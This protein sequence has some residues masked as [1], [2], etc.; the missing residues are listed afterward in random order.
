MG[1][2]AGWGDRLRDNCAIVTVAEGT[3]CV[4]AIAGDA[5]LEDGGLRANRFVDTG[6]AGVDGISYA[7]MAEPVAFEKLRQMP[8]VPM[9]FVSFTLTL[10]A[11]GETVAQIPFRY[12]ED[13]SLVD[14]PAVPEKEGCYGAWPEFDTSGLNSDITLEAEYESLITLLASRE[15]DGNLALVLAEGAFTGD[16]VLRAENSG[17]TPPTAAG[18]DRQTDVWEITLTGTDLTESDTVPLRLLN[19]GGG[20]ADVWQ[21]VDGTWKKADAAANGRYL[22]L[23]MTGTTGTFCIQSS[24]RNS[25]LLLFLAAALLIL[26]VICLLIRRIR[27]K[28]RAKPPKNEE[29]QEMGTA[30]AS[31]S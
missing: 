8:G 25:M 24:Q 23:T 14:L 7:G 2:I 9:E 31:K 5:D 17:Q 16:A 19:R 21:L 13:L 20:S 18:E 29:K 4:G 1:G 6:T 10:V 15:T 22:L 30:P 11:D 3:E 27:K 12:G 26:L 28:K